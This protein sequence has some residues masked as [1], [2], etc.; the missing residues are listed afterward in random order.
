M[1]PEEEVKV[2]SETGHSRTLSNS[3]MGPSIQSEGEAT[4]GEQGIMPHSTVSAVKVAGDIAKGVKAAVDD[5]VAWAE[6]KADKLSAEEGGVGPYASP[7]TCLQTSD[8]DAIASGVLPAMPSQETENKGKT[9]KSE[10]KQ[11]DGGTDN[12]GPKDKESTEE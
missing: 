9:G 1:K 2:K 11:T 8:L 7:A 12:H 4:D 6:K 10:A 3:S 5:A